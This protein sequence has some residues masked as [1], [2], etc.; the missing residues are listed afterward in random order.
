VARRG[1]LVW[2]GNWG[3]GERNA[4]LRAFLVEPVRRLGLRANAYGVRYPADA[5]QELAS[6]GIAYGGWRAN[7]RAP[8]AFAAHGATVHIPRR[9][10][11]EALPGIPTI[12]P[13]EALACGIPLVCSPWDDSE[14]LFRP[15]EDFLVAR[16][17]GE[18]TRHLDDI[19]HEPELAASLARYGLETIRARHTC[20]HRADELVAI[21]GELGLS[22]E[23]STRAPSGSGEIGHG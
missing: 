22:I 7:H 9:P 20:S 23:P 18:M 8:G 17:S 6:A 16:T 12:R 14:G 10:Y 2:I 15:G 4:E 3:D 13:F 1:D 19:V 21:A 11:V 5:Q